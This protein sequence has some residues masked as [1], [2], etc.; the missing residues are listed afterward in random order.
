MKF[1]ALVVTTVSRAW[2]FDERVRDKTEQLLFSRRFYGQR[3]QFAW[4][5]WMERK[6]KNFR[7]QGT[8]WKSLS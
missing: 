3:L 8:R 6:L 5:I 7:C 4:E 2:V 1:L